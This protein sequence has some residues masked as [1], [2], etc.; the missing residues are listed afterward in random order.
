M[1][2]VD[3]DRNDHIRYSIPSGISSS[4]LFQLDPDS[5]EVWSSA[6]FDREE[7]DHYDIPVTA[8]DKNGRNGFAVLKVRIFDV[9]DNPPAFDLVTNTNLQKS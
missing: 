2:A 3:N 5:G 8:T 1:S 6:S 4:G 7:K 9:N